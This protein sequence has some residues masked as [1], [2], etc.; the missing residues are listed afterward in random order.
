MRATGK[1]KREV[2]RAGQATKGPSWSSIAMFAAGGAA[3]VLVLVI[4]AF[5]GRNKSYDP[6]PPAAAATAAIPSLSP[7]RPGYSASP[8]DSR[9]ARSPAGT[10][11][12]LGLQTATWLGGSSPVEPTGGWRRLR[13]SRSSG[14]QE[15][16]I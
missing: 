13:S 14:G 8:S 5:G 7:Q 9:P 11:D 16:R 1:H 4:G 3:V 12:S 2:R 10:N 6:S 15:G